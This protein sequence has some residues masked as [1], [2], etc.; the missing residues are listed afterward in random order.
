LEVLEGLF[1]QTRQQSP[2]NF[3]KTKASKFPFFKL[4]RKGVKV[5][6]A[7]LK[8]RSQAGDEVKAL[9][10]SLEIESKFSEICVTDDIIGDR[11]ERIVTRKLF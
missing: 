9:L 4:V 2:F 10:Y 5:K 11:I 7:Q 3:R 8:I 6:P 1:A